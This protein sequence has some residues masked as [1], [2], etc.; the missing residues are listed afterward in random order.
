MNG[1]TK[2]RRTRRALVGALLA[3]G[4]RAAFGAAPKATPNEGMPNEDAR[5]DG[6]R[7]DGGKAN[8][9]GKEKGSKENG[10]K[11]NGRK[12][13]GR[14]VE[15]RRLRL[16]TVNQRESLDVVYRRGGELVPEAIER[17]EHLLRDRRNNQRGPIDPKLLDLLHQLGESIEADQPFHV[18]SAYRSPETNDK[19]AATPGSGVAQGSLHV[20]GQAID[21]RVP[22][23]PLEKLRDAATA[24]KA[25][26][27]GYYAKSDFVH[28]DVGRVRSWVQEE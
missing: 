12:E 21:I 20:K 17:I 1:P 27:V 8:N 5:N 2:M 25:G 26:G 7:N 9:S 19:R 16:F 18:I 6:A 14:A 23:V 4:A 22:G 15:E 10:R 3:G 24:L 11:E 13:A 28:V